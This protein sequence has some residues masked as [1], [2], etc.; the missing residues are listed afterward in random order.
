[1][2]S[3]AVATKPSA[4]ITRLAGVHYY[5]R[6]IERSRTF[7]VDQMDFREIARSSVALEQRSAQRS[8]AFSAG[9]CLVVCSTPQ[10]EGGR[11]WRYLQKHPDGVGSIVFE[12]EDADRT[13]RYLDERGGTPITVVERFEDAGGTLRTF[14]I[15]TPFGD[16]TFRFLERRGFADL[17]PGI[18]YLPPPANRGNRYGF[19]QFDHVTSNF[20]TMAPALLW[21]EHVMGFERFWD[22]EF[23]TDD[24]SVA[25][26]HEGTGLKSVVMWDPRSGVR[27]ANN[28]PRLPQFKGSQI[29]VFTEQHRGDGVQ[30]LALSCA[31][32]VSAVEG[33][34]AAGVRFMH[35][36]A[37]YYDLLPD[38]LQRCGIGSIDEDVD[39]LRRLGILVDGEARGAYM[40]QIFLQDSAAYH[41]SA[42]AG[43]FFYEIIQRKGDQGFGAGNFRALFESIEREQRQGHGEEAG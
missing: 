17:M 12:V 25:D 43:P 38:R 20:Q 26:A 34:R 33:L 10:G 13:F 18:P 14:S 41:S 40:L 19:E 16:T 24:V 1:M 8:A 42:E 32:I 5:V 28:E 2:T 21:L 29:N 11:A 9:D 37:A 15:T 36:P 3:N 27:F 30:H 39:R 31:D 35:T 23:H 6:D 7:Y 4:G 22:V